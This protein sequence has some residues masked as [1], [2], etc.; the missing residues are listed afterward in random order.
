[1]E[2]HHWHKNTEDDRRLVK[3]SPFMDTN[4]YTESL[5]YKRIMRQVYRRKISPISSKN[6]LIKNKKKQTKLY[7]FR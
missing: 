2:N 4:T 5:L 1:M 3:W 7:Q 6:N